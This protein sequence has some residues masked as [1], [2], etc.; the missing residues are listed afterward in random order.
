MLI[1]TPRI[2]TDHFSVGKI[3]LDLPAGVATL[4]ANIVTR[5]PVSRVPTSASMPQFLWR[6][7]HETCGRIAGGYRRLLA[8]RGADL[9]L[10]RFHVHQN[11]GSFLM[12]GGRDGKEGSGSESAVHGGVQERGGQAALS[13]S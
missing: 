1:F 8:S 7:N 4:L 6:P 2:D 11:F 12:Y 9:T 5:P 10:P 13:R 3:L